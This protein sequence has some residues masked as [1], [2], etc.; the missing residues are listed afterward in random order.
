VSDEPPQG[1]EP[2]EAGAPAPITPG[3]SFALGCGGFVAFFV[4]ALVL[5]M[6]LAPTGAPGMAAGAL[7]VVLTFA[8][9]I[10]SSDA[11]GRAVLA[12]VAVGFAI[13]AVLFGGCLV[14]L[15]NADFR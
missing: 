1:E 12:R 11:R 13:G 8:A 2:R 14:L 6:L 9:V 15:S 3:R 4:V 10:W 7:L 5:G